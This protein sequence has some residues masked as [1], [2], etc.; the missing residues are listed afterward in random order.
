MMWETKKRNEIVRLLWRRTLLL[1]LFGAVIFA[2]SSV[3]SIARKER[4]SA[5][6][7]QEA[8]AQ[9]AALEGRKE[10]IEA[11]IKRLQTD[12]GMEEAL[13]DQYSLAREGEELIVIVEKDASPPPPPPPPS[14]FEKITRGLWW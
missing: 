4:E 8:E 13:R 7:R 10:Q 3:W 11:N 2:A 14:F 12:R 5:I 9:L 6:L 1:V